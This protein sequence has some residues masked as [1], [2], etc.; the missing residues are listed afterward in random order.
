VE[1]QNL[2]RID[3]NYRKL[4]RYLERVSELVNRF[5]DSRARTAI[6][7]ARTE[8]E[9]ARKFLYDA[10][11]PR[12]NL[13]QVHLGKAKQYID[14]AAKIVLSVPFKKLQRQLDDMIERAE[15]EL[16]S[17]RKEEVYYLLNQA[18]K[19]RRQAYTDYQAGRIVRGEQNYRVAF[20]F[21]RK[22]LEYQRKAV[23]SVPEQRLELEMSVRQLL[24]Q[25]DALAEND[26]MIA[27]MLQ[28]AEEH[29]R[30]ALQLADAGKEEQAINRLRLIRR[31]IYRI[32]DQADR[33]EVDKKGRIENQ[34]YSLNAFLQSLEED[35]KQTVNTRL[36]NL[37]NNAWQQYN[38]A[39]LAYTAGKL[40]VTAK[41]ISLSQRIAN[42]VFRQLRKGGNNN[43]EQL[44][45]RIEETQR[46]LVFQEENVKN[47][48]NDALIKMHQEAIELLNR[49]TEALDQGKNGLAFQLLQVST[50]MSARI[51]RE[52]GSDHP[53]ISE[54]ELQNKYDQINAFLSRVE[55]NTKIMAKHGV[56]IDQLRYYTEQG[57]NYWDQDYLLIADEYFTTVLEQIRTYIKR[58]RN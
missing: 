53:A 26:P 29:Y 48:E 12:L 23:M 41:K 43:S 49:A 58:W 6:Q 54:T 47:S 42:K 11:E 19:F 15:Q 9:K 18:K 24:N 17:S 20:F 31:F 8:L 2:R 7:S 34:L 35:V 38:E 14:I 21:A 56:I 25:A 45:L 16:A 50:R 30:E 28:E 40:D 37:L 55:N 1:A 36:A 3:S 4:E 52:M 33:G 51:Q 22:C 32:Y 27:R 10:R 44:A 57:K 5:N 13:A 46:I 39:Q